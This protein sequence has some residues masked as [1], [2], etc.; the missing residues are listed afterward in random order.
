MP[1]S[2]A[3]AVYNGQA[4]IKEQLDSILCQ[5]DDKDEIV[6]SLDPSTDH[7]KD[8]IESYQDPRI[9]LIDG[10]GK[11]LITNFENA[12]SHCQNEFI[13]LSDQDDIWSK[14][15]KKKVLEAFDDKTIC[16]VHDAY[17]VSG[18]GKKILKESFYLTRDSR[19]GLLKNIMKNSY[20]GC[21][22]AFRKELV[23]DILPFPQDLPMH[24]QYI[25]LIAQKKGDVKFIK[26]RLLSYRRHE[27][28]SS[29]DTH[30]NVKQMLIWRY[31]ICKAMLK[32]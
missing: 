30:S 1:I 31:Q 19:P 16:I 6:I 17:V 26:D 4:Y 10:K 7:S 20:I 32:K 21:C 25:G 27:N 5:L 28:T 18:D 8:I 2:V 29:Q 13:F 11:G 24:D 12:I 14:H 15:K 23:E 3:M 22:M 9:H